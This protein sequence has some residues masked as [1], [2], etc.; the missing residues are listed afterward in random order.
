MNAWVGN[1]S[2][3]V[4]IEKLQI[5]WDSTSLSM[6]KECARKYKY[7]I[8]DGWTPR[9]QSVHL[10]FGIAYHKA[11]EH[12]EHA[13]SRGEDWQAG[14]RAAVKFCLQTTW[15]YNLKRPWTSDDKNKN[16][17]TLVRTVVWYL[18]QFKNDMLETIILANGKPAV[19][20]SFRFTTDLTAPDGQPYLLCGHLDR[21][22]NYSVNTAAGIWVNDH[23]TTK[24][25]IESEDYFDRYSPDNQM[26][27]YSFAGK[28]VYGIPVKGV[29]V[30]AAQVLV[31]LSRFRRGFANRTDSTL[32]EWYN[33]TKHWIELAAEY[34]VHDYWPMNDKS[35]GLYGGCPF[36]TIC[37]RA[38]EVREQWLVAGFKKRQW[39]PLQVRG[40]I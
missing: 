1:S 35:C 9:D 19:E 4:K 18:C 3:S 29:I 34:A 20:L 7:G 31:T 24:S 25:A 39:D 26:S 36:R 6:L 22:A 8:I 38:P 16:R 14:V 40:D 23:K 2:F 30:N 27:M 28:I 32:N 17:F 37:G 12:Y 11:L 5:G 21:L 10:I 15:D 33:D 13:R